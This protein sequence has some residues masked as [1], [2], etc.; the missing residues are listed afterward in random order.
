MEYPK[1]FEVTTFQFLYNSS[2]YWPLFIQ[3]PLLPTVNSLSSLPIIFL[4]G[5]PCRLKMKNMVYA[6]CLRGWGFHAKAIFF[7]NV[8]FV[9]LYFEALVVELFEI[10]LVISQKGKMNNLVEVCFVGLGVGGKNVRSLVK[11]VISVGLGGSKRY[12]GDFKVIILRRGWGKQ[13]RSDQ[14][15]WGELTPLYTMKGVLTMLYCYFETL[16]QV[17]SLARYCKGLYNVFFFTIVLLFYI[18]WD[19]KKNSTL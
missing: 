11:V 19:K 17:T 3:S 6:V 16:L 13:Q 5:K 7:F 15:L 4:L 9:N 18:Y 14:F 2:F 1:D 12:G 8:F 10:S